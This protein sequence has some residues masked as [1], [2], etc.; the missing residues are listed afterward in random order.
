MIVITGANGTLGSQI[1]EHLLERVP[2]D[3]VGISVRDIGKAAS[4]AERGVRVRHGDFTAPA[5]LADSLEGATTVLVVSAAIRGPGADKANIAAIDA[6]VA[7]GA[8]RILYTSHQAASKTSAFTPQLA[9]AATEAHLAGLDIP[10]V[11]LRHGFYASTLGFALG[12]AASTGLLLAPQ[13][14]PVSWT[15]HPDLAE[16]AA[17]AAADPDLLHGVTPPLTAPDLLDLE[18]VAA[19]ASG[20]TGRTIERVVVDDAEWKATAIERGMPAAAADFTLGMY[21]ASRNGEFAV[22]DPTLEQLLGRP[23]TP[24]RTVLSEILATP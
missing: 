14:G 16:I 17:A 20:I 7:V 3:A 23:A 6:A 10:Y 19:I 24:V 2:A 1:V 22:A 4:F 15:A 21:R 13:D 5:T 9:H 11:A 12:D 18:A 8:T